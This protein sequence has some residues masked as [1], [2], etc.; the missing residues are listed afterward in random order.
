[1]VHELDI[2]SA[3]YI[4]NTFS[5]AA[6]FISPFVGLYISKTGDYWWL[7]VGITP[8][9]LL[10][11]GLLN[12]FRHPGTQVG[13]LVMCQLFNGLAS[14]VWAMTAQLAI[15][16]QVSHQE[17]AVTIALFSLF[18]SI[19]ASIGNAAGAG[20]WT[21]FLPEKL[22]EW[23]PAE[24]QPNWAEIYGDI[25]AQLA[26]PMGSPARTAIIDGYGFVMKRMVIAGSCFLPLCLFCVLAW[27]RVNVSKVAK[28]EG[29]F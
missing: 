27:K 25:T 13:Y 12:Y 7:S 22:Q 16:A 19:G 23:L 24:D 9:A 11:T 15:M 26:F 14:G 6:A 29:T 5:V 2:A 28:R 3:S 4:L 1:M 17:I 18:G 21:N 20:M 10:G 8:L